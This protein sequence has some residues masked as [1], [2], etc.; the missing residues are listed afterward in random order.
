MNDAY[1]VMRFE[2]VERQPSIH[3]PFVIHLIRRSLGV[4]AFGINAYTGPEAG[5]VVIEEHDEIGGGAGTHEELYLVMQGHATFRVNGEE[6]DVGRGGMVFVRDP[7]ARR[8]ATAAEPG[9]TVL[10]IGGQPAERDVPGAWEWAA[11]ATT[12]YLE[13]DYERAFEIAREGL[14]TSPD[15][16]ALLYNLACFAALAG[17]TD[18]AVGYLSSAAQGD[19]A[20][21]RQWSD[22][23]SDLD[24]LRD[25]PDWPL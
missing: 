22:G 2:D 18:E 5:D 3:H 6:H 10:V 15:S 12:A 21:V 20:L 4:R 13:K 25:R 7:H 14:E 17:R 8:G 19:E 24:S 16:P 11:A 9:T 23:D 1:T